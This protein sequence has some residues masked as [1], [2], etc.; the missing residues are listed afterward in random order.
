MPK[1]PTES[2]P[3]LELVVDNVVHLAEERDKRLPTI[4]IVEEEPDKR[5]A[6]KEALEEADKLFHKRK[7]VDGIIISVIEKGNTLYTFTGGL[8]LDR[9]ILFREWAT[10]LAKEEWLKWNDSP[11]EE[12]AET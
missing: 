11:E 8:T 3:K 1:K 10:E 2:K 7:G 5:S 9:E 12:D 6:V 4:Y